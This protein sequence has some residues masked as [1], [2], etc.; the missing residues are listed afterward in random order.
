VDDGPEVISRPTALLLCG[1]MSPSGQ[2]L[3]RTVEAAGFDL[4]ARVTRWPK[5]VQWVADHEVDIAIVELSMTGSLGI[6]LIAVLRAAAP[7]CE[8]IVL[9]SL[10]ELDLAALEAGAAEVVHP[11]DLRPLTAALQRIAADRVHA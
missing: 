6:R 5:A 1:G 11:N 9:S 7:S 4:L 10:D 2:V 8:V 3:E